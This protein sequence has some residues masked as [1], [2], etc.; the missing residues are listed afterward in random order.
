[1]L[2]P[3]VSLGGEGIDITMRGVGF[4]FESAKASSKISVESRTRESLIRE[5]I[6]TQVDLRIK[7][8][9]AERE[10]QKLTAYEQGQKN[11]FQ[12]AQ[13]LAME[14]NCRLRYTGAETADDKPVVVIEHLDAVYDP[15]KISV[16][17][18]AYGQINPNRG[19][20]PLIE[21]TAPVTNLL[22]PKFVNG[23]TANRFKKSDKSFEE[24]NVM[25]DFNKDVSGKAPSQDGTI[26]GDVDQSGDV[27]NDIAGSPMAIVDRGESSTTLGKFKS[28]VYDYITHVF[29][30]DLTTVGIVD[31]EPGRM[32]A[33]KCG[34]IESLE[35]AYDVWDVE[36][37]IGVEGAQTKI[38]AR[39][40]GGAANMTRLGIEKAEDT[41]RRFIAGINTKKASSDGVVGQ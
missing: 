27:D 3:D 26:A 30:Y 31:L 9:R 4:M 29:E 22:L 1:M 16:E 28:M 7:D 19:S 36:H 20:Y 34:G 12:A 2:A 5:L 11:N 18:V 10:L 38:T 14:V 24:L 32:I 33:V 13:E 25:K 35:G 8:D 17:L 40:T 37:S 41:G 39:R 23:A 15:K 21:L 6:G